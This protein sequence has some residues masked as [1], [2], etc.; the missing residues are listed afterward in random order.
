[1]LN[2][3]WIVVFV[4]SPLFVCFGSETTIDIFQKTINEQALAPNLRVR[5]EEIRKESKEADLFIRKYF[6]KEAFISDH[7]ETEVVDKVEKAA[8]YVAGRLYEEGRRNPT[9][10][11][12]LKRAL[13]FAG[14]EGGAD[15]IDSRSEATMNSIASLRSDIE[16]LLDLRTKYNTS[17]NGPNFQ[18]FLEGLAEIL[19]K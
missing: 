11:E 6:D 14:K 12:L 19:R 2:K 8:A 5:L 17:V 18:A 7:F 16:R 10:T 13:L 9:D 3:L 15:G 4:F 1:M